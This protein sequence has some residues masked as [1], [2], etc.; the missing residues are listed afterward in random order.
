MTRTNTLLEQDL[1]CLI[2]A[3]QHALPEQDRLAW[4][5]AKTRWITDDQIA[6]LRET[7]QDIAAALEIAHLHLIQRRS[8]K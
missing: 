3:L 6:V 2:H 7:Q 5:L 8:G 4:D 1:A